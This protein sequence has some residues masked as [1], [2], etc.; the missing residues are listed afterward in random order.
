MEGCNRDPETAGVATHLVQRDQAVVA[1]QSRVLDA[2]RHDRPGRLLKPCHERVV[3]ALLEQ[4]DPCERLRDVGAADD[5]TVSVL[6]PPRGRLDVGAVDGQGRERKREVDWAGGAVE[7]A[8][9]PLD[10]RR[11]GRDRLPKLGRLGVGGELPR[12]PGDGIPELRQR[13]LARGVDEQPHGLVEKVVPGRP[14]H[15]PVAQLLAR[16]QDLL[17]PDPLDPPCTEPLE[18]AARVGE[19]VDVID[20]EPRDEALA[21]EAEH[22]LVGLVEDGLVL[23]PDAGEVIDVEEAAVGARLRVD[24]EEPTSAPRVGPEWVVVASPHVVGDDVQNHLEPRLAEP[25]QL[26]LAAELVGDAGRVDHVV[27]VGRAGGGLEHGGEV[28]VRDAEVAQVG[29]ERP[30]LREVE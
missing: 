22:E 6:D 28:E 2:L 29:D 19:P 7:L 23:D 12:L 24:V 17:D 1:V 25:P 16:L 10:L 4:E 11:K 26:G 13:P 14:E 9:E 20:P 8:V 3:A 27:A 18:V 15:G 21:D 5:L 30:S